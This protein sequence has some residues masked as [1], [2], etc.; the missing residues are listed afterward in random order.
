MALSLDVSFG[1]GLPLRQ[2]EG[3]RSGARLARLAGSQGC[4][5]RAS[6]CADRVKNGRARGRRAKSPERL[7]RGHAPPR[8]RH[9]VPGAVRGGVEKGQCGEWPL[10]TRTWGRASAAAQAHAPVPA[11]AVPA[12]QLLLHYPP[13]PRAMPPV[14]PRPYSP[15]TLAGCEVSALPLLAFLCPRPTVSLQGTSA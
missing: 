7:R 5:P 14:S 13:F 11:L 12:N 6:R 1:P 15:Q 10:R 8:S 3:L 2:P 9:A 4:R